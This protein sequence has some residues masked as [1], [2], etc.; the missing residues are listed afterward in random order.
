VYCCCSK[1]LD[2]HRSVVRTNRDAIVVLVTVVV[3]VVRI[4]GNPKLTRWEEAASLYHVDASDRHT[5]DVAMSSEVV[6][7]TLGDVHQRQTVWARSATG[8]CRN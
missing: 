7:H 1:V 6:R 8:F 4:A 3:V 2:F 5:G